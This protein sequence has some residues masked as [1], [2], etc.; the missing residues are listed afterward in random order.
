MKPA[1]QPRPEILAFDPPP[2][3]ELVTLPWLANVLDAVAAIHGHSE[4]MYRQARVLRKMQADAEAKEA[5]RLE[6]EARARSKAEARLRSAE[7]VASARA[8]ET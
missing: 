8:A 2:D 7:R 3:G 6:R 1:A 5:L 4:P